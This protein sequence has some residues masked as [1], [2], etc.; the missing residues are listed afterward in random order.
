MEGAAEAVP[1][2][3]THDRKAVCVGV[4]LDGV[5][6]IAECVAR[7]YLLNPKHQAVIG[8]FDEFARFDGDFVTDEIHAACVAMPAIKDDGCINI[9]DVAFFEFAFLWNAVT[10]NVVDGCADRLWE[11]L[12]VKRGRHSASGDDVIMTKLIK[13]FGCDAWHNV[14]CNH[15]QYLR[16]K[17]SRFAHTFEVGFA[18]EFYAVDA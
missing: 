5:A 16:G 13:A 7:F 1:A 11:A 18:V 15:V 12:I 6:N 10:H 14:L 17:L 9:D 4:L 3:I 8:D 2:E